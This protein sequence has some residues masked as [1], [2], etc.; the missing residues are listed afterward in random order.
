MFSHDNL[1]VDQE[2]RPPVSPS[3][4]YLFL[5]T[6]FLSS[7]RLLSFFSISLYKEEKKSMYSPLRIFSL[8]DRTI[9][10]P[11]GIAMSPAGLGEA[12]DCPDDTLQGIPS[13]TSALLPAPCA[14]ASKAPHGEAP[15]SPNQKHVTGAWG[16]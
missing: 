2:S 10:S 9:C 4:V 1:G 11:N 7:N 5:R 16:G 15:T 12:V 8:V 13:L 14:W 3:P 6:F